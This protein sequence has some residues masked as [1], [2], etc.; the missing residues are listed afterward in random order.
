MLP[1]DCVVL[2]RIFSQSDDRGLGFL[3]ALL[4]ASSATRKHCIQQRLVQAVERQYGSRRQFLVSA[5]NHG[6]SQIIFATNL[7]IRK[8]EWCAILQAAVRTGHIGIARK[9]QDEH[10][11]TLTKH[12]IVGHFQYSLPRALITMYRIGLAF[13]AYDF[14]LFA[15]QKRQQNTWVTERDFVSA[16]NSTELL[17][18][19]KMGAAIVCGR[20]DFLE[21]LVQDGYPVTQIERLLM[22]QQVNTPLCVAFWDTF[23]FPDV[24]P[25]QLVESDCSE[26]TI[27]YLVMTLQVNTILQMAEIAI[28]Y[29]ATNA[30]ETI[31]AVA[32]P[33]LFQHRQELYEKAV[34][35]YNLSILVVMQ[36]FGFHHGAEIFLRARDAICMSVPLVETLISMGAC[37]D[38]PGYLL[39]HACNEA[40]NRPSFIVIIQAFRKRSDYAVVMNELVTRCIQAN[41][42]CVSI[43]WKVLIDPVP[44]SI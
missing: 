33:S 11:A 35:D 27:R 26:A 15:S 41:H 21:T 4:T 34:N 8:R 1:F 28:E 31:L 42:R 19:F 18:D 44:G 14:L 32:S 12:Q 38:D 9:A 30:F 37:F 13:S 10:D 2:D 22:T 24:T 6:Y 43:L 39:F 16:L 29:S 23:G 36:R 7:V 40:M 25:R 3:N 17:Y 5:A 20:K